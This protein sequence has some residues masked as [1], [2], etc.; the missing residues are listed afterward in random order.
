MGQFHYDVPDAASDFIG[1][2]LWQDAYICGIE[3][4]PFQSQNR[5]DGNRLTITRHGIDSS[6]KLYLACL[7]PGLGYRTLSTCSLR[8]MPDEGYLLPLELARSSCYRARVQSDGWQRAGLNLSREFID[9]LAEGTEAFLES[10]G[11]RADPSS[12]A[13]SA[14]RA[15]QILERSMADLG[16]SYAVQSIAF[17]KQREPHIGTLLAGTVIPPSPTPG[18]DAN[19]FSE[20]FNA[21][22]VRLN[23]A[24]IETDSG[25]FDFEAADNTIQLLN[26]KG[27]RII[28]GPLIDFRE[29]LLPHWLYL[30]EEN[31]ESFLQAVTHYVETTVTHFRGQVQLWNCACGLNT[32]G[33]LEL[34]D[35]QAMRLALEILSTVRRTDPNTPAIMSFDQPFGEYLGKHRD[36]ISPLHFADALVRTGL[37][38]AGIG[39]EFRVNYK[40]ASTLPRSAVDFGL[41]IDRWATLGMPMLVQISVPGGIGGDPSA[42]APSEVLTYDAQ[43]ADAA[44]EQL[45]IAGPMIRTLLAKHIVHGIVWDGWNDSDPHVMSH[46]GVIDQQGHPRPLFEYFKRLRKEFLA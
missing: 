29:R 27:M 20:A 45:R 35:E 43:T 28:G 6:G 44:A 33:P 37:Q 18:E 3:G 2:S 34:D 19:R 11:R 41:M 9:G 15:I 40:N 13:A 39:L 12:S 26:N 30:L 36:A 1:Q 7:I 42:Q 17:R 38:M 24:D 21:A 5:F 14:I 22:A 10:A 31:F 32:Q 4:V 8:P 46:S 16:E 23:W 25:R